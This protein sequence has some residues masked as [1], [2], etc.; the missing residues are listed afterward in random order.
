MEMAQY[1]VVCIRRAHHDLV[2]ASLTVWWTCVGILQCALGG[3]IMFW[4]WRV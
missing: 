2:V 1:F 4:L 3:C